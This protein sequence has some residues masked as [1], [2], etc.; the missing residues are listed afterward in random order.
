MRAMVQPEAVAV[1]HTARRGAQIIGPA[2]AVEQDAE[3][4]GDRR[5]SG[6]TL[7]RLRDRLRDR[8]VID[9]FPVLASLWRHVGSAEGK[10]IGEEIVEH[11]AK[12]PQVLNLE[13]C[14]ADRSTQG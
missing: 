11:H 12:V 7:E 6:V 4:G 1:W 9:V 10:H 13:G 5:S 2:D 14:S 8:W 3:G